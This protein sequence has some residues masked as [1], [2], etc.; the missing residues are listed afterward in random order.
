MCS[1]GIL[2][3]QNGN[4]CCGADCVTCGGGGCGGRVG[5]AVSWCLLS[6]CAIAWTQSKVYWRP[7]SKLVWTSAQT[8]QAISNC[9]MQNPKINILRCSRYVPVTNTVVVHRKM[10]ISLPVCSLSSR[11]LEL[12]VA[13]PTGTKGSGRKSAAPLNL[14]VRMHGM[15][16]CIVQPPISVTLTKPCFAPFLC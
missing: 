16:S 10:N 13:H 3:T 12:N 14:Q 4:I 11:N 8:K 5:G 9:C 6:T 2:G 7:Y 1:N 15:Q